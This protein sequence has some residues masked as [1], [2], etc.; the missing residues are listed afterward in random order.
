MKKACEHEWVV[1]STAME[2]GWLMVQCVRC[3][4]HGTVDDQTPEEWDRAYTAPSKPYRWLD[5]AR[6]TRHPENDGAIYVET[7]RGSYVPSSCWQSLQAIAR[8]QATDSG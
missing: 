8:R 7:G 3:I 6:V 4:A 1:F 2:E 5:G